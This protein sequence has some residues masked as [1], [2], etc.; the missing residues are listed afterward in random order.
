[1]DMSDDNGG[2]HRAERD[3]YSFLS[4]IERKAVERMGSTV[5]GDAVMAMLS[6][7]DRDA[8]HS[9]I[10][11]F[12]QHELDEAKEKVALLNQQGS[13]QAELL[14]L[15]QVHNS[16]P[17]VTH[18]RRPETLKIDIS[19]YR[20][21][22]EDS[23]L[24]WFVEL[25]DAIRARHIVDEQMQVAFAQSNLAGRAKTWAL[26][27]K[28]RDPYVFGSLETFK[29]RLKQTFEP[30]RAEFRARTELLK[31]KQGKRDVHAY[32]QHIRLLASCIT[33]N[34]VHEHTLITVFMQGLT[35]G[36]VK[37][38]L[39]R[40]ELDT[41]EEAISVAEQEDFS[42]R[43]AQASSSSYRPPRRQEYGG[44]EPMDLSYIENEKPRFSNNKRLQKCNRCQKLGHYAHECSAP[45][46]VPRGTDRNY[47][48]HAK[49]GNGR[50]SDVVAKSQQRGGPPK[51]GRGQ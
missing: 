11:K 13:Q 40:L 34:P 33:N 44:P 14:R 45:R 5:G 38:H 36:P 49:K 27:L 1:M 22:E 10:A 2:T 12:I 8:L 47:G 29:A 24:R 50:G 42:L 9:A 19:K 16:V 37:T 17:G 6:G 15:Q 51:N 20:G 43:Q 46:P 30:P 4:E 39:F 32:A 35:D 25:D 26:S 3:G 31:L 21:V 28:L 48:P 41:L 7:L 18:A 23:L